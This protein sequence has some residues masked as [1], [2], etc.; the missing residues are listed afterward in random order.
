MSQ[1]AHLLEEL[2]NITHLYTDK[3][4]TLTKNLMTFRYGVRF[5]RMKLFLLSRSSSDA[6]VFQTY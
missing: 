1:S 4:G 6:F 3:T 2:G 5:P